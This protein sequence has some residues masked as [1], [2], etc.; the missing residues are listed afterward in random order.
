LAVRI[1][2][3]Y[4]KR[5]DLK[6]GMELDVSLVD[7]GI[8]LRPPRRP[9]YTLDELVAGITPENRHGEA[10]WGEAVGRESW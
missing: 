7:S 9:Q 6:E 4:A 10:D 1:P 5:L 2:G 8:L 3:A